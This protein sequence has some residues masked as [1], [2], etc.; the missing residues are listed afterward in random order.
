MKVITLL[1]AGGKMGL[2]ISAN[3]QRTDYEVR[4]V[5]I[6]ERGKSAL[7]QRGVEAVAARGGDRRDRGGYSRAS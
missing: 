2:R 6:S 7:T 3:L 4:Y 1:G 5:E